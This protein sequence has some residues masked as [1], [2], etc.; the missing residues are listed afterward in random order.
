MK[1]FYKKNET[2]NFYYMLKEQCDHS[3]KAIEAL[4]RFIVSKDIET[5]EL[6]EQIEKSADDT[7]KKTLSFVE[8][9]F[10]TPL[11]RHDISSISRCLDDL[12][13]KIKDLKDFIVF[14]DYDAS[15]T[16]ADMCQHI[17]M[18]IEGLAK[19]TN[20]WYK[21]SK[22]D[23]WEYLVVSK[24]SENEVKR[25]YWNGIK[26]L[27]NTSGATYDVILSR[28]FSKDL[29]SLANKI[30]KAADRIGDIKIKSI[31]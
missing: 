8:S 3:L 29:N 11:D 13:D 9:S 20:E 17:C 26:E 1:L 19:A 10:V 7:R 30:G 6:I 27:K 22:T 14:F 24:R 5:A 31:K 16:Q 18:G 23:L 12:T 25:L 21:S 15:E 2:P 4:N 28:E